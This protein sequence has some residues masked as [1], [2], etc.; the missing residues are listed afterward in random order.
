MST[1]KVE[2]TDCSAVFDVS[3]LFGKEPEAI[4]ARCE[5]CIQVQMLTDETVR[6]YLETIES[7]NDTIRMKDLRITQ[8]EGEIGDW[9]ALEVARGHTDEVDKKLLAAI[10]CQATHRTADQIALIW[11]CHPW[12]TNPE[13]ERLREANLHLAAGHAKNIR[14]CITCGKPATLFDEKQQLYF[15]IEHGEPSDYEIAAAEGMTPN[16]SSAVVLDLTNSPNLARSLG[17]QVPDC[18]YPGCTK[19]GVKLNGEENVRCDEH[20]QNRVRLI[21]QHEV[22]EADV[23]EEEFVASIGSAAVVEKPVGDFMVRGD[24]QPQIPQAPVIRRPQIVQ[25]WKVSY[26]PDDLVKAI[27]IIADA[28]DGVAY[29]E[30][31]RIVKEC[32]MSEA[33]ARTIQSNYRREIVSVREATKIGLAEREAV[34]LALKTHFEARVA[35]AEAAR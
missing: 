28:G 23:L 26:S 15:C 1:E 33:Q 35:K 8:L 34:L 25:P 13:L 3:A 29:K 10:A 20:A 22:D 12:E 24:G 32:S 6:N 30:F 2:G 16:A 11:G 21:E 31:P 18:D 27:Q 14:P 17:E 4:S 7:K 9:Q 5:H 19:A